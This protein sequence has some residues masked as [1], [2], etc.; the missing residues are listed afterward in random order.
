MNSIHPDQLLESLRW[1]YAVK[2]F[3]PVRKIDSLTWKAMEQSM[4]LAPSSYGL[5]PWKFLVVTTAEIKS[6]LPA[7]SWNQSQPQDC[8]HMVVMA[9][10]KSMDESY[11]DSYVQSIAETRSVP[12]EKL[13][14]YRSM[15]LGT[16]QKMDPESVRV[17]NTR[18][19]YIAL[20]QLMTA[21]AML[22]VDT[23]PMEGIDGKAYDRVLGLSDSDYSSVVGCAVGYRDASDKSALAKKVR[24]PTRDLVE[25][26]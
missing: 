19:V 20:G 4:V 2:A 1:R 18:Q 21:A 10:R 15:M 8:S 7:I 24:F 22:G 25:Y 9:V 11:I 13:A 6:Q 12:V 3:D 26:R 23:C 14:P 5:Q 16:V 17:W